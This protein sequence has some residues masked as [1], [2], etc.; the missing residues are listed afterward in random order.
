MDIDYAAGIVPAPRQLAWQRQEF[1]GFIHF[2][3]NTFTDQEWGTGQESPALFNPTHPGPAPVGGYRT[4]GR[5]DR[6]DSDLQTP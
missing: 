3:M 5:D 6:L 2:G 1:Y 4:T